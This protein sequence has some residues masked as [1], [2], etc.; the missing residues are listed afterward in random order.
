MDFLVDQ[1]SYFLADL[2]LSGG[3]LKS[4][5]LAVHTSDETRL[6]SLLASILSGVAVGSEGSAGANGSGMQYGML[7]NMQCS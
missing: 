2:S 7:G 4:Q 6:L 5:P 1:C 3:H